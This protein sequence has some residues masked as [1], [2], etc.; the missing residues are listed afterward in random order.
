MGFVDGISFNLL[1]DFYFC[2]MFSLSDHGF[3]TGR[4][5]KR[6]GKFLFLADTIVFNGTAR[7]SCFLFQII[8]V[9]GWNPW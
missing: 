1:I 2:C 7:Y 4:I 3:P 9:G 5:S 6:E 8:A